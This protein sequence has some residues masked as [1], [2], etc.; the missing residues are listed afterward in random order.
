VELADW[1]ISDNGAGDRLP[2]LTLPPAGF[3]VVAAASEAFRSAYPAFDGSL[4]VL[5]GGRIGNGLADRGDRLALR[6]SDGRL[7]D[8]LSYG[9]DSTILS[10]AVSGVAAGHSLERSPLGHDTDSAADFVDNPR[11]SPGRGLRRTAVLS[12][13]TLGPSA[14]DETEPAAESSQSAHS[15]GFGTRVWALIGAGLLA[16]G[17]LGGGGVFYRRRLASRR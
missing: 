7:A 17:G 6:D 4:L 16:L 15:G 13:T 2:P 11:P 9:E 10:P 12:A 5:D 3:A 8:A 14:D 1:T